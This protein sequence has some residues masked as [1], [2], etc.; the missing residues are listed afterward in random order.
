MQ[1]LMKEADY[2]S[3]RLNFKLVIS[4]ECYDTKFVEHRPSMAMLSYAWTQF[5]LTLHILLKENVSLY[6]NGGSFDWRSSFAGQKLA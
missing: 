4:M 2:R 6:L 1:S 5:L 3:I